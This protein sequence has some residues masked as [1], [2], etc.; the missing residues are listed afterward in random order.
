MTLSKYLTR[1]KSQKIMDS[2]VL[3]SNFSLL[4]TAIT[5]WTL[6]RDKGLERAIPA[7]APVTE[8]MRADTGFMKRLD[9]LA[10]FL[11][12]GRSG[13][14]NVKRLDFKTLEGNPKPPATHEFDLWTDKRG[15]RGF[16]HFDG[17]VFVLDSVG[18]GIGHR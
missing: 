6:L 7:L 17:N 14:A 13:D 3:D 12:S 15:W 18:E 1:L 16:G 2:P 9:D 10:R 5:I 8:K 4:N 11:E